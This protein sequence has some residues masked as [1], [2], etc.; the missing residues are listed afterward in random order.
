[1]QEARGKEQGRGGAGHE[2]GNEYTNAGHEWGH[3]YTNAANEWGHEYTNAGIRGRHS[4]SGPPRPNSS[5]NPSP[6]STCN[7]QPANLQPLFCNLPTW[8]L[9][10]RP[11][12]MLYCRLVETCD[13]RVISQEV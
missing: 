13:Y 5:T 7:L 4:W 3:E 8:H 10:R 2:W 6:S 9:T 1:M 12:V 11:E